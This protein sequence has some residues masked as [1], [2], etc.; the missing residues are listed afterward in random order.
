MNTEIKHGKTET[1]K[2]TGHTKYDQDR[3]DEFLQDAIMYEQ[4][5]EDENIPEI[6]FVDDEPLII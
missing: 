4:E 5:S 3:K 6:I 1:R 2:E